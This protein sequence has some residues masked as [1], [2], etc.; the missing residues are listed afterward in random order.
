MKKTV[1]VT[2]GF[3]FLGSHLVEHFLKEGFSVV[4]VDNF[5]TGSR[6]NLEHFKAEI[7]QGNLK[8]IEADVSQ[9]WDSWVGVLE[10]LPPLSF[11]FHFAS[12][13]SPP[14]Y[15][16]LGLE[17]LAVNSIGLGHA[18]KTA[19]RFGARV[20]FASTSEVYGDP[21][22]NP[23]PETYWGNVNSFGVRSC[24]DEAKRFGE[25]LIYTHNQKHQTQHGLVRIFNTYG[26][27]MNPADGR[28]IINLLLQAEK[29]EPMTLYGSGDQT[30]SFC[31]V[32]D[33]ISGIVKY[34]QS[35]LTCPINL[36]NDH[37]FTIN[38]L[39]ETLQSIYTDR[40]LE[41]KHLPLPQDDPK[42]RKP[43]LTLAKRLLSPWTPQIQ[44]REGLIKMRACL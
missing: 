12:P 32:D 7:S 41:I 20:I 5:C 35:N 28:V 1:L 9:T 6:S 42:Q 29:H 21:S 2:G 17:T 16:R 22:V 30:R 26:P 38:Q 18:L 33:L 24:Y 25:A 40:K 15:Q 44:L 23:Q 11:V 13:A 8:T 34:A 19:D 10:S 27:R 37:E 36:G 31:Y 3:G 43:D 39:A 14:H 4:A